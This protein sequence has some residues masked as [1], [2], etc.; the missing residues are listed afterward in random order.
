MK[1]FGT[2]TSGA[3]FFLLRVTTIE[4]NLKIMISQNHVNDAAC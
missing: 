1:N 3:I 2:V 4:L